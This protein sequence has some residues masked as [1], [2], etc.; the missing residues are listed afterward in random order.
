MGRPKVKPSESALDKMLGEASWLLSH[1]EALADYGRK[2]EVLGE[3]QRA[4]KCEEQVAC[5]L[6]AAKREKEAGVHRVSAASCYEQLGEY[7]RAVTLLRAALSAPLPDDY[8]R[9]VEQQITRCLAQAHKELRRASSRTRCKSVEPDLS[10]QA[11]AT[12]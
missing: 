4:A 5:W 1:A 9:G 8:Q 10:G 3:L 11:A 2:E 7:A 12:S 6:D